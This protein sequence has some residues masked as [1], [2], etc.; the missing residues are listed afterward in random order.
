MLSDLAFHIAGWIQAA[1]NA[2]PPCREAPLTLNAERLARLQDGDNLWMRISD[3][4]FAA[5]N[6]RDLTFRDV[7]GEARIN[8]V[9]ARKCRLN[10][11]L[12][13]AL[14]W[15][16]NARNGPHELARKARKPSFS[17]HRSMHLRYGRRAWSSAAWMLAAYALVVKVAPLIVE[18]FQS[19]SA[20]TRAPTSEM[21]KS[22]TRLVYPF[23]VGS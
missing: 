22:V 17:L 23:W 21:K 3:L 16:R 13:R 10:R 5:T 8:V 6:S 14:I 9:Q 12:V 4:Q 20:I 11:L 19:W 2:K 7:G 18:S 1:I 15:Y